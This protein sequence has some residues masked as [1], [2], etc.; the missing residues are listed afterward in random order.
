MTRVRGVSGGGIQ[1]NKV[2]QVTSPKKEP[3][4][5]SISLDAVSRIGSAVGVG[6]PRASLYNPIKASTPQGPTDNTKN[7]GPGGCGRQVLPCGTQSHHSTTPMQGPRRDL[8]K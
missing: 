3:V 8:F 4:N 5:H 2:S 6:T 7:L 1:G